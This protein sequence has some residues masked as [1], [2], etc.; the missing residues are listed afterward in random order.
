MSQGGPNSTAGSGAPPVESITGNSG[1]AVTPDAS[2]NIDLLGT[3][4]TG[5]D[6]VGTPASSLLTVIGIAAS[7]TQVG[8]VE[9]ATAAETTT[10]TSTVL[11]VHPSGL[12][13][14]LGAQTSNGLI[15]GGGGAGSNLGALAE[16]TDGQLPIGSTGNPPVLATITAGSGISIV[17]AAGSITIT[18]P[19][20][21]WNNITG[22]SSGMLVNEG[23]IA[24]NVGL[25]T[26]TLPSTAAIGDVFAISGN[27]AGG[28]LMA[29][30]AGQTCHLLST[31]TATGA[32]GSLAS[33]TRYDGCELICTVT[34][35][36]F[37][38]KNVIGNLTVV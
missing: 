32:G 36:D 15:Y 37:V 20:M 12:D 27:G 21:T 24:N 3:N 28:W 18:S 30:N 2:F 33:T 13:T 10:G 35:T 25:V 5:I 38:V 8:T 34:N 29:Q 17:N 6:I 31:D 26:L 1:G 19:G 9:L 4:A 14:K 23:Y 7:E 16:A 22:T 11:A